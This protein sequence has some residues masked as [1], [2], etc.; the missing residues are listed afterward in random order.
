MIHHDDGCSA[1]IES[2]RRSLDAREAH[3]L[4]QRG[5][6]SQMPGEIRQLREFAGRKRPLLDRPLQRQAP[7]NV[8][9]GDLHQ[10]TPSQTKRSEKLLVVWMLGD[11]VRR[12]QVEI[13]GDAM[14]R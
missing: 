9:R 12:E 8:T 4:R 3:G 5:S 6:R 10:R 2:I 13:C 7:E 14:S 11:V 1:C